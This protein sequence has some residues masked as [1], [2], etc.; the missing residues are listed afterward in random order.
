M[1]VAGEG[2]VT[3]MQLENAVSGSNRVMLF[4]R[5]MLWGTKLRKRIMQLMLHCSA[6]S[7]QGD[8]SD[9]PAVACYMLCSND[10]INYKLTAGVEKEGSCRDVVFPWYPSQS[11]SHYVFAVI[12]NMGE[13]SILTA[14][15]ADVNVAWNNRLG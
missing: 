14:L 4:T 7:R 15:E 6:I 1:I 11:Y 10:G 3:V 2:A 8:T 13:S 5:P 12:G 9:I